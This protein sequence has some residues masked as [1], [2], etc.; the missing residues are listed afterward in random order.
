M[1]L[2]GDLEHLN[3]VDIIQL[4]HSTRQSGIFSIKGSLGESRI[5]FSAGNIVGATHID[6]SVRIGTVLVK[7]G[8]ITVDDLRKAM[9]VAKNAAKNPAPLLATLVQMG[10]L[11]R[12]AALR[13]LQKLVELTIVELMSWTKGTFTF[14]TDAL[15]VSPEGEQGLEAIPRW[16]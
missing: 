16:F 14:D 4:I 7:T 3:I 12:D 8:V 15:V 13:G 11:K 9:G 6:N 10:T 1:A 5:I 2:T